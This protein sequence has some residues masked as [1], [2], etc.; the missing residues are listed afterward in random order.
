MPLIPFIETV[1]AS[2][3]SGN[4]DMGYELID[5]GK[6]FHMWN[7]YDDY[8]FNVSSGIQ[9]TNHYQKYWTHNVMLLGYYNAGAWNII[10][11]TDELTGFTWSIGTDNSTYIN[12][13]G[14]KDLTYAGY[15]FRLAVRY[16]LAKDDQDLTVIPYI[17]NLGI[18][19]PFTLG[20][21]WEIRDIKIDYTYENDQIRINDTSYS[22]HQDLNKVYTNVSKTINEYNTSY[23]V[24]DPIFYLDD[25]KDGSVARTLYLKWDSSLDYAVLVKSAT[26]QYNAV[27]TWFVKIGTL[28][29][30][31]EKYTILHWWDSDTLYER[32][33]N[34]I[35]AWTVQGVNWVSQT[36]TVGTTGTN[37]N[38]YITSVKLLMGRNDNPGTIN[39]SIKTVNA[40]GCPTGINL[41]YGTTNGD[42]LPVY[43]AG[44]WR[45]I[46]FNTQ[47]LLASS[48]KYAIVVR[49][50]SGS[51]T[52]RVEWFY[53]NANPYAGGN[54]AISENTG[55]T[56]TKYTL[57]DCAFQEYGTE[58]TYPRDLTITG[59]N[60]TQIS[61]TWI[62]GLN[63]TVIVRNMTAYPGTPYLGTTVYNGTLE[64]FTNTGLTPSKKYY[65]RAWNW[66]GTGMSANYTS[67][68]ATTRPNAPYDAHWTQVGSSINIT[69]LNGTGSKKTVLRMSST[70]QPI[71][72]QDGTE[73]YNG[74][75]KY[76][77]QAV[78][79]A[80]YVT[81]FS[82][83]TT[84]GLF[85]S[86]GVNLSSYFVYIRCY[87]ESSGLPI[88]GYSVF[89]TNPLGTQT[90]AHDGCTTQ[91]I[92]NTSVIP[93]GDDISVMV[94]A[95]GYYAR[96]YVMDIIITGNYYI[97]AYLVP[98]SATLYYL[99]IVETID[100]SYAPYDQAVEDASV[101]IKRYINATVG[102][103][104]VSSLYTDANGYVNL[105]LVPYVHYKV[106]L[107]K[108]GYDD[109]VSEYTPAPPNEY[110]Q[111]VEKWFR[112]I[113]STGGYSNLTTFD[114][115][116]DFYATMH[117]NNTINIICQEL[118][119]STINAQLYVYETY[120]MTTTLINTTSYLGTLNI[121]IWVPGINTSRMYVIFLYVNHSIIGSSI[122]V[123][124]I[125]PITSNGSMINATDI[126]NK[127][128]SHF[129][130]FELGWVTTF[131][132]FIPAICLIVIFGAVHQAGLGLFLSGA[133][134]G[135]ILKFVQFD[136]GTAAKMGMLCGLFIVMG[137]L[138]II[139]KR[140]GWFD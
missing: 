96:T 11:R 104:I 118:I 114:D 136:L 122:Q 78:T 9:I 137:I 110:G 97:N 28:A 55:I 99:R 121:N 31:Q 42:T 134:L 83:N 68:N 5:D 30:G 94:N 87:N 44:E 69:W 98:I 39:V 76:K 107:N 95:T 102:Y 53:T 16:C 86:P 140:K 106:F 52:K 36:F 113:K 27:V 4:P 43:P 103:E 89:F 139:A 40:T 120:N 101:I 34:Q 12:V 100:S 77:V 60:N 22:L 125:L 25:I 70:T 2:A 112:I 88:T 7:Q 75:L 8:Y 130:P 132:L 1:K 82:F 72:P 65:Y 131:L 62:K 49:A 128:T 93:Q 117:T 38:H 15:S 57:N 105:Q 41:T 14:Y 81:L 59:F 56:W 64:T 67:A 24:P 54:L 47:Y 129:G 29:S 66:N 138:L 127:I 37:V 73:I 46:V 126:E 33:E 80:F 108:S 26:G 91:Y 111:T 133:Y 58:N 10:Y 18:P 135:G 74:T 19:I 115:A 84:T 13:T 92:V 123:L 35:S 90:Y 32:Q 21:A 3:L 109:K 124:H 23:K 116:Y 71:L 50:P 61:M 17:K 79:G 45:E 20:F 51:G 48:T 6:T 119:A 85:S 63:N